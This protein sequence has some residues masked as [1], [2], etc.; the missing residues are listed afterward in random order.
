[1]FIHIFRV[2]SW[3][4]MY[5]IRIAN[6]VLHKGTPTADSIQECQD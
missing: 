3:L 4:N 1:M 2:L 5:E 6:C